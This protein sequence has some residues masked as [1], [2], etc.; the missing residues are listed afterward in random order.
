MR[1]LKR[2]NFH[3]VAYLN[4]KPLFNFMKTIPQVMSADDNTEI[5]IVQFLAL[6]GRSQMILELSGDQAIGM[7]SL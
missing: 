3:R 7:S 2:G 1:Y 6:P 5:D 4:K